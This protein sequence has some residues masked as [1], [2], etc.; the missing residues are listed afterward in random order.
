MIVHTCTKFRCDRSPNNEDNKG[1]RHP[2]K[3]KH[4]KKPSPIRVKKP[5]EFQQLTFLEMESI[6][7]NCLPRPRIDVSHVPRVISSFDNMQD[8]I[9]IAF[10][11]CTPM[12]LSPMISISKC[13]SVIV[14]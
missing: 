3:P 4:V 12:G 6:L 8:L 1:R 13:N 7:L 11:N 14:C 2:P 10:I 9:E 5:K